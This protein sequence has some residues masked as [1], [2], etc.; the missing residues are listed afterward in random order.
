MESFYR[1]IDGFRLFLT[2][3]IP[4]N[5]KL[6]GDRSAVAIKNIKYLKKGGGETFFFTP[7]KN[8]SELR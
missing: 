5:K 6:I 4:S 2:F 3:L 8:S 7:L 1:F